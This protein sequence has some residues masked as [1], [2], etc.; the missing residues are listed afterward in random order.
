MNQLPHVVVI[1]ALNLDIII[2]GLPKFAEPGEQVNGRSVELSPGGKGRNIA[3]MVAAW[4]A[5]GQVSMV[6][7]L[8]QDRY[9]LYHIPMQ[10]L[11]EAHIQTDFVI[12][13][14]DRADDLPTLAVFLNTLDGQ[15]ANYYLPGENETLSP[16]ILE[17]AR[18]L[19]QQLADNNGFLVLSLE[20][21]LTTACY[22]LSI[23]AELGIKV[24]LD[25]GGQPPELAMDTT[26][27]FANPVYL[28]K[29]NVDEASRLTGLP[30]CDLVSAQQAANHL[31]SKGI[32]NV[33]ITHGENGAYAF[34][35]SQSWHISTP[36]LDNPPQ[37]EAT[38][39][40]D[41]VLAVLCAEILH[42]RSFEEAAHKAV[43]A[44]SIQ[45]CQAGLTPVPP[46]HPQ[47]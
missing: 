11:T 18:P 46:N 13:E 42:G 33:L 21:P 37:A 38:G 40:G 47:L 17:K 24:M 9:G 5:P 23:A 34:T 26:L 44:G 30:V 43:R 14:P 7:K 2:K 45:F 25:P 16:D 27:L 12:Q 22:A 19:F 36:N 29:P 31:L 4:L 20:M 10:S 15:R 41:Q 1:G 8:V 28:I 32:K 3:V 6:S 35:S 39:C